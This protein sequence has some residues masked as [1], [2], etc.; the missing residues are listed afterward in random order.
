MAS[1]G[2][3]ATSMGVVLAEYDRLCAWRDRWASLEAKFE[4]GRLTTRQERIAER[5]RICNGQIGKLLATYGVGSAAHS[6]RHGPCS[7]AE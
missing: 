5:A 6:E 1:E 4:P 2:E 3:A 7:A